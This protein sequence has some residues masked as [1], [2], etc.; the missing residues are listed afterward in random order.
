MR[1]RHQIEWRALDEINAG[2]CDSMTQEEIAVLCCTPL[3]RGV[4]FSGVLPWLDSGVLHFRRSI[5]PSLEN[6]RRT[7]QRSDTRRA[8]HI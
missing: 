8:S 7:K 2:I 3:L 1:C 4:C 6:A 5:L